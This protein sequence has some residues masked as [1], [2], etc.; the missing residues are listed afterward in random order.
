ML[1]LNHTK[2]ELNSED[3]QIFLNALSTI[4]IL[5]KQIDLLEYTGEYHSEDQNTCEIMI[6]SLRKIIMKKLIEF[7]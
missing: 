1:K 5:E 4:Y 2:I 7:E 3:S 6:N